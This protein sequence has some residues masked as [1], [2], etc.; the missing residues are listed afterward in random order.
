MYT[1]VSTE[2]IS[3]V[4]SESRTFRARFIFEDFTI[5]ADDIGTINFLG[6]GNEEKKLVIGNAV[7]QS[8]DCELF[9]IFEELQDK[10]FR[11]ETGLKLESG[12]Y[13]YIPMGVFTV[14]KATTKQD[15]TTFTAYD[16]M[17]KADK[18]YETKLLYPQTVENVINDICKSLDVEFAGGVDLMDYT[19][20]TPPPK[21]QTYREMIGFIASF[22]GKSAVFDREGRL[23]FQWFTD[24]NSD[25][26]ISERRIEVPEK[27]EGHYK[28][29]YLSVMLADEEYLNAG[30][31]E[32]E[33]GIE[34]ENPYM[35]TGKIETAWA[36]VQGFEYD[37]YKIKLMLYDPRLDPFDCVYYNGLKIPCMKLS[38]N[39]DGGMWGT[40]QSM[41]A[42]A[43]EY[44]S[45]ADREA[46]K[47]KQ[48]IADSSRVITA[49]NGSDVVIGMIERTICKGVMSVGRNSTPFL[50]FTAQCN[51]TE[52]KTV[53]FR[54]KA[55]GTVIM[56]YSQIMQVGGNIATFVYPILG[57]QAGTFSIEVCSFVADV[58]NCGVIPMFSGRMVLTGHG[59]NAQEGWNGVIACGAVFGKINITDESEAISVKP[60]TS[61]PNYAII[62]PDISSFTATMNK[63][64][65]ADESEAFIIKGMGAS[66]GF[67]EYPY[68]VSALR[69]ENTIVFT[70]KGHLTNDDTVEGSLPAFSVTAIVGGVLTTLLPISASIETYNNGENLTDLTLQFPDLSGAS[71]IRV[72]YDE[73]TGGLHTGDKANGHKV[74]T[75]DVDIE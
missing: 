72:R 71:S 74:P 30:D 62:I 25:F 36:G 44:E 24:S 19:M 61:S 20:A 49:T 38:Y 28:A 50:I 26:Q 16:R 64:N 7:S 27:S 9:G 73:A 29:E 58:N 4:E 56:T 13:E 3:A 75:F 14:T 12:E 67:G 17:A 1:N 21:T 65:I 53:D 47:I 35:T 69:T 52:S 31:E 8:L 33:Q 32:G 43:K 10:E 48:K 57:L 5:T 40:V 15:I 18:R 55:N 68:F 37:V 6:G 41:I 34:I 63:I 23:T 60:L 45:P 42:Q 46:E 39:Y 66:V 2:Y 54:I 51:I 70:F 22:Y 59:L 11:F